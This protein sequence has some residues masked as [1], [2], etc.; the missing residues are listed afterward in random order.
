MRRVN[1]RVERTNG[2]TFTTTDYVQAVSNGNHIVETFL[3]AVDETSEK[4]KAGFK[5]HRD[6][7]RQRRA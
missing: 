4:V 7:I 1:Y 5:A 6:K 3:T 2:S